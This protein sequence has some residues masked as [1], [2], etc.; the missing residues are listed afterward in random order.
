M[1]F[2]ARMK[3]SGLKKVHP[4]P[5]RST[6]ARLD[7]SARELWRGAD[8]TSGTAGLKDPVKPAQ[9]NRATML[10]K[11]YRRRK[12]ASRQKVSGRAR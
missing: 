3:K 11:N 9:S 1:P 10:A 4:R 7:T 5:R 8:Y 2:S 6:D 12:L